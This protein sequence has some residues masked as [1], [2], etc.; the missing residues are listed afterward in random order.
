MFFF[1][2]I[3]CIAETVADIVNLRPDFNRVEKLHQKWYFRIYPTIYPPCGG[4]VALSVVTLDGREH[5]SRI[6]QPFK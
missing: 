6:I 3:H 2:L 4:P 1:F 5:I